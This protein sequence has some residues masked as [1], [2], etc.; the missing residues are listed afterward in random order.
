MATAQRAQQ[1]QVTGGANARPPFWQGL[2]NSGQ[3][4]IPVTERWGA[5]GGGSI[6][7]LYG[8]TR[9]SVVG[10]LPLAAGGALVAHGIA[11][12]VPLNERLSRTTSRWRPAGSVSLS[13]SVTIGK[14][15]EEVYQFWHNFENLPRFMRNLQSVTV[16]GGNRSHWVALAGAAAPV[17]W[18]A[19]TIEDVPNQRIVWRSLPGSAVQTQGTVRF[20]PAPGQ[21][22]TE[23]HVEMTYAGP[24]GV[25]TKPVAALLVAMTAQQVKNDILRLKEV[26]ET[27]EAATTEGQP[28]GQ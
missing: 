25:L 8:L 20:V 4:A 9:K 24:G 2:T 22:G 15:P 5:I 19:E 17:E 27:G 16:T 18:D 28:Q 26:M 6:L 14:S 1:T 10:L 12:N 23:V 13:K 3:S 11:A 7:A 21:R